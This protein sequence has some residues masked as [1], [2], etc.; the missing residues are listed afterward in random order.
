MVERN[1]VV[2]GVERLTEKRDDA[3]HVEALATELQVEVITCAVFGL[4][5]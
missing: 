1:Q 5:L 3:C 4:S 2:L